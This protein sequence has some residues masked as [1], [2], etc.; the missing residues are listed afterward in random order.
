MNHE[1]KIIDGALHYKTAKT[2]GFVPFTANELTLM[3]R[4]AQLDLLE[5]QMKI[6]EDAS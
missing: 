1:E 2:V 4:R 5:L 6:K 3:L